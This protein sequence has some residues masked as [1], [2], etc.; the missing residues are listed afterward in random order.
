MSHDIQR[1]FLFR[2]TTASSLSSLMKEKPNRE[3]SSTVNV[4]STFHLK[5]DNPKTNF[6]E[7]IFSY[8][9]F[10]QFI[11]WQSW[12]LSSDATPNEVNRYNLQI[13][14]PAPNMGRIGFF[15]SNRMTLVQT[16]NLYKNDLVVYNSLCKPYLKWLFVKFG[17]LSVN[18]DRLLIVGYLRKV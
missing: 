14:K 4:C 2:M 9:I 8:F 11:H 15:R 6:F 13:F 1:E 10:I 17:E 16:A 7:M 3:F 5:A 12:N 18:F